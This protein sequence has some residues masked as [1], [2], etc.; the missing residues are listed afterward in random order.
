MKFLDLHTLRGQLKGPQITEN[1]AFHPFT[2]NQ[3]TAARPLLTFKM[4]IK[5]KFQIFGALRAPAAREP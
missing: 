5:I 4:Q 1:P 3:P 2:T